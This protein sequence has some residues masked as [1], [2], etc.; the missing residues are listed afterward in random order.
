MM[1]VDAALCALSL[2]LAFALRLGT[3][4]PAPLIE[5]L[6]L[7][8]TVVVCSVPIFLAAGM[9][10]SVVRFM[11]AG[12]ALAAILGA[13][14]SAVIF[15][16]LGLWQASA[17]IPLTTFAIFWLVLTA[18]LVSARMVA[19]HVLPRPGNGNGHREAVLIYGAGLAGIQLAGLLEHDSQYRL[20]AFIDD[21]PAIQGTEIRGRR[22]YAAAA[23]DNLIETLDIRHVL[24]AMPSASRRR[25][26][27]IIASLEAANV[28]IR[29]VPGLVDIVSGSARVDELREVEIDDLL[30][31]D[32]MPP[33]LDLLDRCIH[34]R[35]VLVTGAG[36]S[37]GSELCRQ[38]LG[39]GPTRLVLFDQSE[40]ALYRMERELAAL[41]KVENTPT[42][43]EPILGDVLNQERL[44]YILETRGIDTVYHAAAYKHVPLVEANM[45]EGVRNNVFG[46]LA[47]VRAAQNARVSTFVL[48]STDKAVR[49][50]SV[51]GASKRVAEL[52]V[53]SGLGAAGRNMR[54][55]MVRFGNVLGSSGSVVPLFREQIR[56]G[57]PITVT[58]PEMTRYLMTIP[59]AAQLVLQAGAMGEDGDVF[60]L[61]MGEPVRILDL[62]RRMVRLSGL[63][64]RD[65]E[66]PDGDIA[67]EYIGLRPGEKLYEELL[68]GDNVSPTCHAMIMRASESSMDW[69]ILERRLQRLA[70]YCDQTDGLAVRAELAEMVEGYSAESRPEVDERNESEPVVERGAQIRAAP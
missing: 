1:G 62:A 40:Y 37:I 52:V 15:L 57:G 21:D 66:H 14:G 59:E 65:A 44:Q 70:R 13:T 29:T 11:G 54:L 30:D 19:W 34:Q 12:A 63:S 8:A 33:N 41:A 56:K 39:R 43:I 55:S 25:R 35:A 47:A 17:A 49:P 60:V 46:T 24:L 10:R 68:I 7:A 31:R 18:S 22:V 20:K 16:V 28:H 64:V 38:I 26:R 5:H 32:P 6:W 4:L 23:I 48:I 69:S 53:Q 67:I 3:L 42:L 27:A 2:W 45:S 61:D 50:S 9:Y 58:H 36:G 51:M